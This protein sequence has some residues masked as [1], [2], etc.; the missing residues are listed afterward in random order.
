[1]AQNATIYKFTITLSDFVREIYTTI[2][3]TVALHPS[4]TLP[5]MMARVL[6]F[7][8]HYEALLEFTKGLSTPETPDIWLHSFDGRVDQWI[9]V[10]EPTPEKLKKACRMASHVQ[11]YSF[12]SKSDV[13]WQRNCMAIKQLSVDVYQIDSTELVKLANLVD[14]TMT[15]P[16]NI[17]ED[18]FFVSGKFEAIEIP[19]KKL[20]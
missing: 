7:C 2:P 15:L 20:N 8:K 9:E 14:R 18:N 4:E 11:V 16:I 1:M 19:F 13:W 12:N 5:R 6:A 10:G 17:N 3:M